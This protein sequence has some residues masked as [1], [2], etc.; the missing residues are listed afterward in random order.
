MRAPMLTLAVLVTLV[1]DAAAAQGPWGRVKAWTGSVTVEATENRKFPNYTSTTSYKATGEFT[2]SDDALGDGDHVMWPMANPELASD[3]AKYAASQTPWQA[4]VAASFEAA[5]K[6][7]EGN[8]F[9]TKCTA[10]NQKAAS[11]GIMASG[12][13][14][15]MFSVTLPEAVFKCTTTGSGSGPTPNG[16]FH[17]ATLQLGGPQGQPG[18]VTGTKTFTIGEK[19]IKVS[20]TMKPVK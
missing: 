11:V 18:P 1:H 17:Q 13:S 15:Y 4:R 6:D 2:A 8:A 5:G 9:S 7:M 12:D 20:F 19:V 16:R 3:P 14:E 10:D